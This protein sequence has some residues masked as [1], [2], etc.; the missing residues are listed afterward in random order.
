MNDKPYGGSQTIDCTSIFSS[1]KIF[2]ISRQS[3]SKIYP[4]IISAQKYIVRICIKYRIDQQ[5]FL[6]LFIGILEKD[7]Y[8]GSKPHII[9]F[10]QVLDNLPKQEG[11]VRAVDG[12]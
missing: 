9:T 2:K 6:E 11:A 3:P 5:N 8:L 10:G 4:F 7:E 1:V 12:T